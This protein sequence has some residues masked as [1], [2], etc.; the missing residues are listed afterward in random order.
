MWSEAGRR[1]TFCPTSINYCQLPR[2]RREDIAYLGKRNSFFLT[3][4]KSCRRIFLIN[5]E[6]NL[7]TS[8]LVNSLSHCHIMIWPVFLQSFYLR[9]VKTSF[10][11]RYY[12]QTLSSLKMNNVTLFLFCVNN[13][14]CCPHS[15]MSHLNKNK[16]KK[17]DMYKQCHYEIHFKISVRRNRD[18]DLFT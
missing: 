9:F 8:E 6:I 15:L 12:D 17:A 14:V 13:F 3:L 18:L 7:S 5:E 2:L 11:P 16:R 10:L 1:C 4:E